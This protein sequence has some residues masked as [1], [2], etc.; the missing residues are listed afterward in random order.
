MAGRWNCTNCLYYVGAATGWALP[1]CLGGRGESWR[2]RLHRGPRPRGVPGCLLT[3]ATRRS[4]H[5][6][7]M[8]WVI[9]RWVTGTCNLC[10]SGERLESPVLS[11]NFLVWPFVARPL[12]FTREQD[13]GGREKLQRGPSRPCGVMD[14][15][16][17]LALLTV[18]QLYVSL[19]VK[20]D[21]IVY[22]H[23]WSLS[24]ITYTSVKLIY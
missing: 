22:S 17:I 1:S 20:T 24:C 19:H 18:S 13:A 6:G 7:S 4:Q 9:G 16:P 5:G 10:G 2:L 23:V 8:P 11:W 3:L 14:V 21:Q 12:H 15:F